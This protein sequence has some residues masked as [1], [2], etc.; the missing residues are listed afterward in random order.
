MPD[1]EKDATCPRCGRYRPY[2]CL[3]HIPIPES[4]TREDMAQAFDEGVRQMS[5]AL[6]G[7]PEPVNPYRVTSPGVGA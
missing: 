4:Y 3:C 2:G 6:Q 7:G 1:V 5:R